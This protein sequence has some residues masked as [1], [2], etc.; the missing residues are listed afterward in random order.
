MNIIFMGTP[1]FAVKSL[2]ILIQN[3]Y[4]IVAVITSADRPS[5]RGQKL[6]ESEV[7]KYAMQ[8]DL[9]VLQPEK[10][11]NQEFLADLKSLNADL[12]I[13]VAFRMLPEEVWKMPPLGTFNLH[14]SLLP[15]YRGAAPI[16]WAIMNGEKETGATTFFIEQQIDTGK[17][18]FQE[19]VTI[20][21]DDDAGTLHDKLTEIG[22][23]LV[24][25]TVQTIEKGNYSQISQNNIIKKGEVL[26]PAPK[27]FKDDCKI[28]W[29]QDG[30]NIYNFVRGLSPYPTAWTE[31][32][33]K[34]NIDII[35]V[36]IFKCEFVKESHS[37]QTGILISDGKNLLKI[38]VLDGYI[39]ILNLQLAGKKQL[40]VKE[41]LRGFQVDNWEIF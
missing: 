34:N 24:L 19:K 10:L 13:V 17:I 41:F 5:G 8:H 25:K 1:E 16:N 4:T 30:I 39:N 9:K 6:N 21:D 40:N 15:Q 22:A 3:N 27:I 26:N 31:F 23:N 11:K 29:N 37:F 36:K 7:K 20:E 33:K 38:S 32:K 18:I 28:N 2:Q 12:Q 35:N 14:A